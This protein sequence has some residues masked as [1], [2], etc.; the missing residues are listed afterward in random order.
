[1]E[2]DL[3]DTNNEASN[4]IDQFMKSNNILN[5]NSSITNTEKSN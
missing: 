5:N 4:T 3:Y 2:T 1:M